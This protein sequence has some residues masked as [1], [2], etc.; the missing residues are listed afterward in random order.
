M[1]ERRSALI[2]SVV[3]GKLQVPGVAEPG[4]MSVAAFLILAV[5][6]CPVQEAEL[7]TRPSGSTLDTRPEEQ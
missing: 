6:S 7:P 4:R 1:Q 3:T 5:R 2:S